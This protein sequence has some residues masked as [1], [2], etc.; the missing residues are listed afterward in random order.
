MSTCS[1]RLG[2]R[3]VAR[4]LDAAIACRWH[5]IGLLS[6]GSGQRFF[7]CRFALMRLR[8]LC[9]LIFLRRFLTREPIQ[10]LLEWTLQVKVSRLL[11][12][13]ASWAVAK[14]NRLVSA[15]TFRRPANR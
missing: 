11:S 5:A 6:S 4:L 3:C 7:L 12:D 8:Y 9:L 14:V 13:I 10:N 15:E 2:D 1:V